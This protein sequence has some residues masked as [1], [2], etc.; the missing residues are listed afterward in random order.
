MIERDDNI[1]ALE[2][3]LAELE[4]ARQIAR[5]VALEQAA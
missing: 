2:E 1:P 4:H 3:L 5:K